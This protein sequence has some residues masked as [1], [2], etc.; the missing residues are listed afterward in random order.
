[1]PPTTTPTLEIP[2]TPRGP[3]H[4]A[5]G[6]P[7]GAGP[8]EGNAVPSVSPARIGVWLLVA[9]ITILFAAFTSTYL[10]RR[11]AGEWPAV[12]LPPVLWLTTA[13][14]L[15][16]SV[17][18]EAARRA[19]GRGIRAPLRQWLWV[20]TALGL[21]FLGGQLVAWRQLAASG[22]FMATNPHS[23]FFYLLTGA[24]GL[25]LVGGIGALIFAL[26]KAPGAS[27]RIEAM[28]VVDPVATYWH[29]LD[30]LWLYLFLILYGI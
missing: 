11:N 13:I 29:F 10:V 21:V 12:F 17:T 16:S 7:G 2:R 5:G 30:G 8:S 23:A 24:H 14:L 25:H 20:T 1:M 9:G 19:A 27:T 3:G 22:V 4:P 18:I 6:D 26:A 28:D 15:I